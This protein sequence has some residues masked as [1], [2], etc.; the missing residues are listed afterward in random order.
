MYSLQR[1]LHMRSIYEQAS[2]RAA[3]PI[4]LA[5]RVV[6]Q[7]IVPTA[8]RPI[9]SE[10]HASSSLHP[11]DWATFYHDTVSS[12]TPGINLLT[13]HLGYDGEELRA[14]MGYDSLW[15]AAWRSRDMKVVMSRTFKKLLRQA[16]IKLIN[17]RQAMALVG[18]KEEENA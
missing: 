1:A 15:G 11:R 7:M 8:M 16:G 2:E 5:H 12:L 4:L 10:Y 13:V 6:N 3:L 17:W 14:A 9:T 18:R